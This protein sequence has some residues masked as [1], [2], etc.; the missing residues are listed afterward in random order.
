M[1]SEKIYHFLAKT[2]FCNCNR[3]RL[4]SKTAAPLD[5]N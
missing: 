5:P 4:A 3:M 2:I 1:T